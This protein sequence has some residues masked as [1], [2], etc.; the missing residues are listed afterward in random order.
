MPTSAISTQNNLLKTATTI[1]TPTFIGSDVISSI[2]QQEKVNV[3]NNTTYSDAPNAVKLL[4]FITNN[5]GKVKLY[6]EINSNINVGDKVFIMYDISGNTSGI[7]DGYILDNFLEFS[8]CTDYIY[9][10][11]MQ[12]YTVLETNDGNNEITIDRWYDTRLVNKKIYNHYIA[13]IYIR[14]IIVNGGEFDGVEI[15]KGEFNNGEDLSID[16]NLVQAIILSGTS[17]YIRFKN[18]YDDLYVSTNSSINTGDTLSTYKPYIYKGVDTSNQDPTP[19]SSYY[20]NNNNGYGYNYVYYNIIKESEI[21][22]GYFDGCILTDCKISG[23]YFINC[24]ISGPLTEI[25]G[26]TFY[27]CPLS[28]DCLWLYGIWSGGTFGANVWYNGIWNGGDFIGK[29]WRDGIFNSGFFS[30][31]TWRTGL[32]QGGIMNNCIWSGGTFGGGEINNTEWVNGTFNAGTMNFCNW[33]NGTCNGGAIRNTR[34]SN[35]TF[36]GGEMT[37]SNWYNGTCYG[38]TLL[39]VYWNNGTFNGGN[40]KSTITPPSLSGGTYVSSIYPTNS[41]NYSYITGVTQKYWKDGTFNGGT[42]SNS[43]WSGGT[44]NDGTFADGSLWLDGIFFYG[45]FTNSSWVSGE[46]KNGTVTRSYFHDVIWKNGIWNSGTLGVFLTH[47]NIIGDDYPNIIWY[48]G[49]FNDGVFGYGNTTGTTNSTQIEW[50][51]GNF[52]GGTFYNGYEAIDCLNGP[53]FGGFSGGTFWDG[54]FY[55]VFWRGIWVNGTFS[56]CNKAGILTERTVKSK[57]KKIITKK[58]GELPIKTK[59]Q[60]ISNAGQT[61]SNL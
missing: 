1:T 48:N 3:F 16:I 45:N 14:N 36:N 5:N 58:F 25:K 4:P 20:T 60:G 13:E 26:G 34:W 51:G 39:D 31:S 38:G 28:S 44:F 29:E 17:Y 41:I 11:Q 55:G 18:K 56:G 8:G 43:L 21:N 10:P 9:L 19:V 42:F 50:H 61:L 37:N 46:F 35:G 6:T 52:Y 22:S 49:I 54:Y 47:S 40:Y 57:S 27:N 15:L 23:G 32:F 24:N 33:Y 2:P 59:Q 7:T 53:W 30:G 12:G